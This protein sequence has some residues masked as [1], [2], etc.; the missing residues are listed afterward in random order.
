[1]RTGYICSESLIIYVLY[2]DVSKLA[3]YP[4]G[5]LISDKANKHI[6]RI[7]RAG[8]EIIYKILLAIIQRNLRLSEAYNTN[9]CFLLS[10]KIVML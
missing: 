9:V 7:C 2:G 5:S 4:D 1:M 8:G 6:V 10:S 3:V